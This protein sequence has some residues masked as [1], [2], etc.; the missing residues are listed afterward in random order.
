MLNWEN[1]LEKDREAL[2]S[3]EEHCGTVVILENFLLDV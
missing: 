1:L 3:I 2:N